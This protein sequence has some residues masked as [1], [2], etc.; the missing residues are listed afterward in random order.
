M[1]EDNL[2][3]GVV[4]GFSKPIILW[5]VQIRPMYGYDLIKEFSRLTGKKLGPA[6]VYPFLHSLEKKGYLVG[7]WVKKGKRQIKSYTITRKGKRLLRSV[8]TLFGKP[9]REMIMDFLRKDYQNPLN[10][11]SETENL[12]FEMG[13]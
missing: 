1:N 5:L 6:A 8:T 10:Y 4:R 2:I 13:I 9:I 7:K 12:Y 3:D 11:S